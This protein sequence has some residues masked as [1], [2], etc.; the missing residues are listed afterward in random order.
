MPKQKEAEP[1]D[2]AK[3]LVSYQAVEDANRVATRVRGTGLPPE[4]LAA[5]ADDHEGDETCVQVLARL[6]DP[7]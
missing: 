2:K 5:N 4:A 7:R 6:A 3:R 1:T